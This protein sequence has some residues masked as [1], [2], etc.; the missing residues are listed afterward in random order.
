MRYL[1]IYCFVFEHQSC[2]KGGLKLP[3]VT[4]KSG[5]VN[6]DKFIC[7]KTAQASNEI[8]FGG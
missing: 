5:E 8:K 7:A 2:L 4:S 6:T 1:P 3:L